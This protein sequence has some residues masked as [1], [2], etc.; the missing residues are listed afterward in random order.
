MTPPG[1][2]EHVR[3]AYRLPG[4][5]RLLGQGRR[6]CSEFINDSLASCPLGIF[7]IFC[8]SSRYDSLASLPLG[9][10]TV[11]C[12]LSSRDRGPLLGLDAFLFLALDSPL[13]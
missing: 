7:S 13:D 11:F 5:S 2:L 1:L 10:F 12:G 6:L 9:N 8:Q 3:V 4:P